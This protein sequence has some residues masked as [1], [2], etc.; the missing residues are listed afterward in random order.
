MIIIYGFIDIFIACNLLRILTQTDCLEEI[1]KIVLDFGGQI[2]E[3][4][5]NM[6]FIFMKNNSSKQP[7]IQV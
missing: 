2:F 6:I 3:P 4:Y 5:F 7:I 1:M